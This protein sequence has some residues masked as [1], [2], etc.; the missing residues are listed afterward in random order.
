MAA[1]AWL[2]ERARRQALVPPRS[3][4]SDYTPGP[5]SYCYETATVDADEGVVTVAGICLAN[6]MPWQEALANAHLIT[7]APELRDAL[8]AM[9]TQ[10]DTLLTVRDDRLDPI[11]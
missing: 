11:V 10:V 1:R 8:A 6:C 7:A 5:W 4:M 3:T 2:T 9:L